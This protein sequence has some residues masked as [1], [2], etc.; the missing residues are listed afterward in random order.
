MD[1]NFRLKNQFVSSYSQDPGLGIG[2]TYMVPRHAYEDYVLSRVKD[3]DVSFPL[4]NSYYGL[5]FLRLALV[6]GFKPSLKQIIDFRK[7]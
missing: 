7:A 2:W 3:E 1:A 5:T 6:L 4:S